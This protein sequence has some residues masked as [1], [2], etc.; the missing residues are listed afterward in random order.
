MQPASIVV[1]NTGAMP[2]NQPMF[3]DRQAT[4]INGFLGLLL[5]IGLGFANLIFLAL[6]PA[7]LLVII[8]GPLWPVIW[9]S[10][11]IVTQGIR[12]LRLLVYL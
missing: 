2:P 4:S 7:A 3:K 1:D 8:T 11:A 10:Y 5:H 6:G 12:L 9:N